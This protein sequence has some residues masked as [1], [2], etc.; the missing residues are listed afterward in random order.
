MT[1][2]CSLTPSFSSSR[3]EGGL[4]RGGHERVD[5]FLARM[6]PGKRWGLQKIHKIK[7]IVVLVTIPKFD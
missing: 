5:T 2:P 7:E 3:S 6:D 4:V 1:D